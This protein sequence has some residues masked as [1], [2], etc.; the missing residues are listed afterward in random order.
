MIPYD[1]GMFRSGHALAKPGRAGILTLVTI[2]QLA[3][4]YFYSIVHRAWHDM[5]WGIW[6]VS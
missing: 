2:C 3:I 5:N 6:Q 1:S 4:A